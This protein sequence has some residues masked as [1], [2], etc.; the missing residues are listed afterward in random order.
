MFGDSGGVLKFR[1]RQALSGGGFHSISTGDVMANDMWHHVAL[2]YDKS[3]VRLFVNGILVGSTSYSTE[4]SVDSTQSFKIGAYEYSGTTKDGHFNGHISNLRVVK[5]TALYTHNFIPPTRDL[6]K[7]PG[8]V[9]LCCQD[10][11]N[12]LTEATGK[13]ITGYGDLQR[14]DGVELITNG[15]FA[16][17]LDNWTASGVQFSHTTNTVGTNGGGKLM[18]YA[19]G[20]N[21]SRNIYQDVPTVS[22]ARYVLSFDSSSDTASANTID[23]AGTSVYTLEDNNNSKL[24]RTEVGFTASSST[25]RI[26]FT[27]TV[28]NRA[29]LDNVSVTLAEGSNKGSNFT[30]QVGDNRKVTFEGVTKVN[31]DAYFYLPTGDTASRETTGTYNSGTRGLWGGGQLM[32]DNSAS[33]VID[34]VTVASK[35][36]AL[37]F[38][39]LTQVRR[40]VFGAVASSTR[41]VWAGGLSPLTDTIDFVTIATK[42]NALDFGN[43]L[44]SKYLLMLALVMKFVEY[45]VEEIQKRLH[46]KQME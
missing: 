1:A 46:L 28:S 6:K 45:L 11:N 17:S 41:G 24:I 36:D 18:Y 32:S 20:T 43:Q 37:D 21:T 10:P 16:S 33:G 4:S 13:T 19:T 23:I 2:T 40:W 29:Y 14:A 42:G 8:T 27:S 34:Y 7:I 15:S 3:T 31:S 38:G 12:P 26:R 9:L 25:T 39:D 44:D 30:P 5:G 35:G 22:G